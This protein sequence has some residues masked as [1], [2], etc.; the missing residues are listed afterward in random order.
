MEASLASFA[1]YFRIGLEVG[2]Y[3]PEEARDWAIS[4][5]DRMDE[6]P[7][8]IIEVSWHKPLA[9]L[10]SDLNEV[11]GE[12]EISLV[13]KWLLGRHS[14]TLKPS[15]PNSS[16]TNY[17]WGSTSTF[18]GLPRLAAVSWPVPAGST[19]GAMHNGCCSGS[20]SRASSSIRH[21]RQPARTG[22]PRKCAPAPHTQG[23]SPH[24]R[25]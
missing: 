12:P 11:K 4:V 10:I 13:C 2:L 24:C 1:Q 17:A 25:R 18:S 5:I 9:Q 3:E 16:K 23:S 19:S 14:Q 21:R 15:F 8:E 22:S 20:T 6:P 7:S